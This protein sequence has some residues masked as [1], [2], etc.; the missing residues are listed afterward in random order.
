[1]PTLLLIAQD[2]ATRT[3]FRNALLAAGYRVLAA[4]EPEEALCLMATQHVD[5]VLQQAGP[6]G[7]A[8]EYATAVFY[9]VRA[10]YP[11]LPFMFLTGSNPTDELA[12]LATR[13][14]TASISMSCDHS[15]LITAVRALLKCGDSR[16]SAGL[17][18]ALCRSNPHPIKRVVQWH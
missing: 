7:Q 4:D 2:P 9:A 1:M 11:R 6:V 5:M 10:G 3:G 15:E 17:S 16:Q 18:D 12:L 13:G 14:H 8:H